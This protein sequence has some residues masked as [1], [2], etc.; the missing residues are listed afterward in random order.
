MTDSAPG[1][2]QATEPQ[3]VT[4]LLAAWQSGD[5]SALDELTPLIYEELRRRARRYMRREPAGHTL[6]ATAIVHEA[7][8]RLMGADVRWRDREHF[9]AIAARQMRRI[10]VD[11]ARARRRIKR[12]GALRIEA[13]GPAAVRDDTAPELDLLTID[14]AL[15]RLAMQDQQ[16]ARLVELHYF[17]GLSYAELARAYEFSEATIHR[18]LRLARAWLLGE[19]SEPRDRP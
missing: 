5:V 13:P 6:Q 17:A 8:L 19:L 4:R 14:A 18:R 15:E 7:L 2:G 12:G 11:H 10:L 16:L 9:F 3:A 1:Y